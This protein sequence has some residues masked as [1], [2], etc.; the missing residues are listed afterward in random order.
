[1]FLQTPDSS[2]QEEQHV[3]CWLVKGMVVVLLQ[4]T[5]LPNSEPVKV[6]PLDIFMDTWGYF[7]LC[8]W[9]QNAE[10]LWET[11]GH[12]EPFV[13]KKLVFF[14]GSWSFCIHDCLDQNRYFKTNHHFFFFV[15]EWFLCLNPKQSMSSVVL[16]LERNRK[17]KHEDAK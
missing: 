7:Q 3:I 2:W 9:W 8:L 6:T 15:L 12:F 1:M 10:F 11:W 5:R 16:W 14:M 17:I 13:Y 4:P